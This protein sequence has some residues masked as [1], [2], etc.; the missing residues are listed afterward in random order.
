MFRM[1]YLGLALVLILVSGQAFG[2]IRDD[3]SLVDRSAQAVQNLR[4][5]YQRPVADALS[6]AKAVLVFPN[7]VQAGFILGGAGGPGMLSVRQADGSW[8]NPA[9]YS[10]IAGS[11]GL[12]VGVTGRSVLIAVMSDAALNRLM[13]GNVKLGADVSIAAGTAGGGAEIGTTTGGADM[14]IYSKD[15]GLFAGGAL[16]GAGITPSFDRD[17]EFYGPQAAPDAILRDLRK[18]PRSAA[19]RA[20]LA[21]ARRP[22]PATARLPPR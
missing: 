7:I 9:F 13:N 8:S 18:D 15:A 11:I 4:Q 22:A 12:Q 1:R 21:G 3:Q 2:S 14:L 10:Y 16:N 5:Q 19:L 20:E 17:R 6:R